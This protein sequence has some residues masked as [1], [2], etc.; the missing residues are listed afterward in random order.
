MKTVFV[1]GAVLCLTSA[2]HAQQRDLKKEYNDFRNKATQEYIRFRNLAN[3]EYAMFVRQ[4]WKEMEVEP[5]IPVPSPDSPIQPVCPQEEVPGPPRLLPFKGVIPNRE[6]QVRPNPIEPIPEPIV[7][8]SARVKFDYFGY[9]CSIRANRDAAVRLPDCS[10][11]SISIAWKQLSDGRH[12]AMLQDCLHL[13]DELKLCDWGYL[14]LCRKLADAYYGSNTN[15]NV[16]LQ[17]FILSQT[18]YKMRLA[19]AEKRLFLLLPSD[20]T[21]YGRMWTRLDDGISYYLFDSDYPKSGFIV[22][23]FAFPEEKMFSLYINQLPTLPENLTSCRLLTSARFPETHIPICSNKN[24]MDFFA[25]Y[26]YCRWDVHAL[27]PLSDQTKEAL[28]PVLKKQIANKTQTE[29]ANILINFVQTAFQYKTDKDQFGYERPLFADET[30]NY[31]YSDCED[32]AILYSVLI[33]DL[34]GLDIV[35]LHYPTHLATAVC[36]DENVTGD[37]LQIDG[38]RYIVCDP[39]YIGADIGR[40]MPGMDNITAE[41]I[42]L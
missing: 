25:T 21:I 14:L 10:G 26:P 39:T 42:R 2:I 1:L 27:T 28:Y 4:A 22:C 18:G 7:P 34:L 11:T 40:T 19:R 12:N 29:A 9:E 13:R 3:T 23:D 33:R 38:R 5:A 31:P 36:F 15:D 16:L 30:L 37:Y 8:D 35:L 17:A 41:V 20:V 6:P 24:L 32:W